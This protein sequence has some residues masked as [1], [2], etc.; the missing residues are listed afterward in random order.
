MY[1]VALTYKQ[2]DDDDPSADQT[3]VDFIKKN[4]IK[5]F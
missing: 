4:Q 2:A 1:E 5:S 3:K